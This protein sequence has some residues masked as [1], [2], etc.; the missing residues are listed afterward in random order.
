MMSLRNGSRV[1]LGLAALT[2]G[3][4]IAPAHSTPATPPAATPAVAAAGAAVPWA[5]FSGYKRYHGNCSTCHGPDGLGGTFAPAL[6]TSL[7]TMDHDQFLEIVVNG[8]AN[9]QLAMPEFGADPNVMCYI[10]DIYTY[11]K[12]RSDGAVPRGRPAPQP[13]RPADVAEAENAC[14]GS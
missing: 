8:K 3:I 9:A 13:T 5:V 11:L 2:R 7:K 4:S 12:A 1:A 6:A 10:E 14:M